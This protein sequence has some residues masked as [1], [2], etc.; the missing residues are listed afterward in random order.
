MQSTLVGLLLLLVLSPAAILINGECINTPSN[1]GFGCYQDADETISCGFACI[2]RVCRPVGEGHYSLNGDNERRACP[3][4]T[5]SNITE[6]ATCYPCPSDT[7]NDEQGQANC[8]ACPFGTHTSDQIGQDSIMDCSPIPSPLPTETPTSLPSRLPVTSQPSTRPSPIPS[9]ALTGTSAPDTGIGSNDPSS[10][11]ST[12]SHQPSFVPTSAD[13]EGSLAPTF[14]P[15]NQP[16]MAS[17]SISSTPSLALS[18]S[19]SAPP[20]FNETT[21]P[22][23]YTG[24]SCRECCSIANMGQWHCES[25][26]SRR[27]YFVK[28]GRCRQCPSKSTSILIGI[29]TLVVFIGLLIAYREMPTRTPALFYIGLDYLQLLSFL[30]TATPFKWPRVVDDTLVSLAVFN[31]DLDA[32]LSPECLINMSYATKELL[33][34]SLLVALGGGITII[35]M[36]AKR[37]SFMDKFVSIALGLYYFAYLQLTSSSFE[38]MVGSGTKSL[39]IAGA[40]AFKV[41]G[42]SFPLLVGRSL[43][44]REARREIKSASEETPTTTKVKSNGPSSSAARRCWI[45]YGPFQSAR[46]YWAVVVLGRK[47]WLVVATSLWRGK[48]MVLGG[49]LVSMFALWG[50]MNYLARPYT[51]FSREMA[52]LARRQGLDSDKEDGNV[53]A[54]EN[55]ECQRITTRRNVDL[56]LHLSL[57]LVVAIGTASTRIVG[58]DN[59][60]WK[61]ETAL[62][63]GALAVVV[64]SAYLLIWSLWTEISHL[65]QFKFSHRPHDGDSVDDLPRSMG[66]FSCLCLR[67]RRGSIVVPSDEPSSSNL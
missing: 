32:T 3:R 67:R 13:V 57:C 23:G 34:L 29:A 64:S 21:C 39:I 62:S 37:D 14:S 1:C 7:Y 63:F 19:P 9:G 16:S 59:S 61:G 30:G 18:P 24:P 22:V 60:G 36:T 45:L 65:G 52:H 5:Y 54:V 4:T 58:G 12:T 28:N 55:T 11:P 35:F 42:I 2:A 33:V 10:P 15:S 8:K 44:R 26:S 17:T 40:I 41:Y 66:R 51:S 27:R 46:W 38:A 31:F 43:L 49:M 53:A 48:P 20:S 6:G 56:L 25:G 50:V 47:L